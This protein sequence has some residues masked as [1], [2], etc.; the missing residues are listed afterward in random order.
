MGSP[1]D[2]SRRCEDV[3]V[4]VVPVVVSD[5]DEVY[6]DLFE[7]TLLSFKNDTKWAGARFG[8]IKVISNTLVGEVGQ[9]FMENLCKEIN[10]PYSFPL[11]DDGS[12]QKRGPWDIMIMNKKYELKTAT[13]DVNG[14]F[15]FNHI[16]YHRQ[17]D[18]LICLGISPDR[19][20]F[21]VWSAADVKTGK[22]GRL[23]SMEK[24]ANASYK[25]TKKA[26]DLQGIE[27][28]KAFMQSFIC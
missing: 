18:G 12:R 27:G 5:P 28:F 3:P 11:R 26:R 16:R 24:N 21:S 17:Y 14:N 6:L 22:A 4:V 23:V 10:I 8:N 13:E 15:Q 9:M 25:L 1:M 20:R 7:K 2:D 19:I